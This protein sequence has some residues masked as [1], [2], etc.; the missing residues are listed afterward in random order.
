MA[1]KAFRIY[2]NRIVS[3]SGDRANKIFV[4]LLKKNKS[5]NLIYM[6]NIRSMEK[7]I[8]LTFDA[9]KVFNHL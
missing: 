9:K 4:N 5:R 2:N 7:P 8:F 1:S 6:P 3:D